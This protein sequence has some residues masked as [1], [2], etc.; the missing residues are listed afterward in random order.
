M[1]EIALREQLQPGLLDRLLDDERFVT[2][3][4][5]CMN[6]AEF[7]RLGL[8]E[9]DFIGT[10]AARNLRP[11][12]PQAGHGTELQEGEREF[13]F[14]APGRTTALQQ[15]KELTLRPAGAKEAVAL[16]SFCRF[17]AV[18]MENLQTETLG[19][20]HFNMRRLRDAVFRD[21]RWLLNSTSLDSI[22]DLSGFPQ[23]VSSVLNYGMPTLAGRAMSSIDAGATAERIATAIRAFEPRLSK[24]YVTPEIS[25][26]SGQEFA[27]E[28]QIEAEL[29]GQPLP[30]R[31]LMRTRIDLDSGQV[32]LA[33]TGTG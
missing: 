18:A 28:Y 31:L 19:R 2:L 17:H 27:L 24:V 23:V 9:S 25:G 26:A 3:V 15:L 21:L 29:W 14:S 16:Q 12:K 7:V 1:T 11:T 4:Q 10:I 8:K 33:E 20:N 13:W 30:Q 32:S 5:V 22:T 6:A